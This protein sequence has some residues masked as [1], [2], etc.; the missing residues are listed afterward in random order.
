MPNLH[1][2]ALRSASEM[3]TVEAPEDENL[4]EVNVPLMTKPDE[5]L[6]ETRCPDTT[7]KLLACD[8][9][10]APW[11]GT[12]AFQIQHDMAEQGR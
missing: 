2:A 11:Y 9:Q 3:T 6:S 12:V 1:P 5:A 4:I 8:L 7:S 10:P